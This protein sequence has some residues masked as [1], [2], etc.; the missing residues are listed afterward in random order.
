MLTAPGAV[1]RLPRGYRLEL[2]LKI[3]VELSPASVALMN[4]T[5]DIPYQSNG[6]PSITVLGPTLASPQTDVTGSLYWPVAS[7]Y[8]ATT[9][10][11]TRPRSL[12]S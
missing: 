8:L 5:P 10:A 12:M 1:R 7:R 11:G 4:S 3:L 6:Y 9:L 2:F